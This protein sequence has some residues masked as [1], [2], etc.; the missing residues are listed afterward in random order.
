[1]L[2]RGALVIFVI[3]ISLCYF[4]GSDF[5]LLS[6]SGGRDSSLKRNHPLSTM[7]FLCLASHSKCPR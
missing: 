3:G 1:M 7:A 6:L 4:R 5:M 2:E